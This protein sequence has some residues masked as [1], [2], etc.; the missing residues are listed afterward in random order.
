MRAAYSKRHSVASPSQDSTNSKFKDSRLLYDGQS[1]HSPTNA[2]LLLEDIKQEADGTGSDHFDAT[3]GRF[4]ASGKRRMVIDGFS[5]SDLIVN[6]ELQTGTQSLTA[7]KMEDES[8]VSGEAV[9]GLFASLLDSA[10]QGAFTSV[11]VIPA[12]LR[13]RVPGCLAS[14]CSTVGQFG[15]IFQI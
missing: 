11:Y 6:P 2:V 14:V 13:N 15:R 5:E 9:L 12:K 10:V 8:A 1:I 7:C 4:Q 3:P